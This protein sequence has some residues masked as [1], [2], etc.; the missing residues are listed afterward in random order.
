MRP[1]QRYLR[2]GAGGRSGTRP[3]LVLLVAGALAGAACGAG[4]STPAPAGP[5]PGR[6]APA[7]PHPVGVRPVRAADSV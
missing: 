5:P 6:A 3:G 7:L 4:T 1:V 2:S